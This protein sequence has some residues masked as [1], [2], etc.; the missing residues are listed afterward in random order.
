M[1]REIVRLMEGY[2]FAFLRRV[3]LLPNPHTGEIRE[4]IQMDALFQRGA[5]GMGV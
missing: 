4:I 3:G 5:Q 1:S 2:G